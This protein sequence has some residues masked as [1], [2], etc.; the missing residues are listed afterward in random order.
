MFGFI[1]AAGGLSI[2]TKQD[3]FKSYCT[4]KQPA[5]RSSNASKIVMVSQ[6]QSSTPTSKD[7]KFKE[8]TSNVERLYDTYPFPPDPLI[9]EAP[10]GY[11]WRWHYPSAYSFV[12]NRMPSTTDKVRIL[13]AG[14]GTGCG[15]EYLVHLNPNAEV[16]GIDLS[17]GALE[18][19]KERIGR[20]CG[21]EGLKRVKL[22]HG[23]LFDIDELLKG[24]DLFDHINCVGVI[25]HTPDPQK[26]LNLLA[27][28]LK[29]GGILHIFVYALYGRW[30]IMLMQKAL[31]LLQRGKVDYKRG[32]ELGRKL[33]KTLPPNNRLRVR[34]ETRWS[35]ENQRD[36][37][38]ADMYCHPQEID[39]TVPSVFELV[40]KSG[41]EFAGFSNPRNFD[42]SRLLGDDP[43]LL[44][45]AESL[46]LKDRL[47]LIELLDP[48][49]VTHF[50]FF[51]YKP[52][53][54]I[55]DWQDD[56]ALKN[57]KASISPCILGWPSD[58]VFDRDYVPF[59]MT[60]TQ[61][62]FAELIEKNPN[63]SEAM[64]ESGATGDDVRA[65]A[66]ASIV[67]LQE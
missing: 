65:L 46:P 18:V 3:A 41:L 48:E 37:T 7:P 23:S 32:V 63:V 30:E 11:N 14:C 24:E 6:A 38:F 26:A 43:E 29:P 27:S 21:E 50:E 2:S 44:Q 12:T 47:E 42:M 57:A 59:R 51:L 58:L 55:A 28:K 45:L 53:L 39:Y 10:I 22:I 15:T 64:K 61:F 52:P 1:P 54:K 9:D 4:T 8:I 36:S 25:H 5:F 35:Q 56:A 19:A 17:S 16:V 33:F 66:K 34:E 62:K 31:R 13:D 20:S 67:F 60:E 49:S 40:Q